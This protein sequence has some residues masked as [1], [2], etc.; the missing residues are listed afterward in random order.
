[1]LYAIYI[2]FILQFITISQY[3]NRILSDITLYNKNDWEGS[4]Q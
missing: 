3:W 4:T 1:M 2:Y